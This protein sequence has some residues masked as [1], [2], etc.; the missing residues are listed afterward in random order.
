MPRK[1]FREIHSTK[2]SIFQKAWYTGFID[3]YFH[4]VSLDVGIW[5]AVSDIK[6]EHDA[7]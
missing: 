5:R 2:L 7:G 1:R 3:L 4:V 6:S